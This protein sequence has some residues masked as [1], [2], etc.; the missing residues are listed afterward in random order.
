MYPKDPNIEILNKEI[1]K[2]I[3]VHKTNQWKEKLSDKWDHKTNTYKYWKTLD[4]LAGKS[5]PPQPNRT[6]QFNNKDK[7]RSDSIAQSFNKQFVNSTPHKTS[8][9]NRIIDRK[10]KHLTD[11]E[12]FQ[13]TVEQVQQAIKSTKN[14]NSLGPDKTSIHHLKHLGPIAL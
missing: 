10:T 7:S 14:S 8:S 13:V 12:L 3:A 5:S 6:I 9:I 1:N 2:L 4:F 11:E